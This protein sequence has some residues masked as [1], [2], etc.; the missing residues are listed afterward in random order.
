MDLHKMLEATKLVAILHDYDSKFNYFRHFRNLL[1][2][3]KEILV[4]Y[5]PIEINFTTSSFS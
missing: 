2:N 4:E 1:S 3:G 5:F